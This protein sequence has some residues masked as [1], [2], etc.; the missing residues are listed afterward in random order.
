[1]GDLCNFVCKRNCSLLG[2]HNALD[3]FRGH[4]LINQAIN[5]QRCMIVQVQCWK[6]LHSQIIEF[7]NEFDNQPTAAIRQAATA[8]WDVDYKRQQSTSWLD[9]RLQEHGEWKVKHWSRYG[10]C[11]FPIDWI[12]ITDRGTEW[13]DELTYLSHDM[14]VTFNWLSLVNPIYCI[15]SIM[16]YNLKAYNP[17]FNLL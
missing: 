3:N 11:P 9:S 14:L 6:I 10:V 8:D 12:P 4:Q 7:F 13:V 17:E 2:I 1:M 15:T 5:R 16:N